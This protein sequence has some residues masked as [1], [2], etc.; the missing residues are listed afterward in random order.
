M[1][2]QNTIKEENVV[3]SLTSY[4]IRLKNLPN[5]L[6]T[7]YAQTMLPDVVVLNLAYDEII[8]DV[9]DVYLKNHRVIIN[10][11]HDTKVYKKIIP[12]FKLFPN[13]CVIC[14]DDDW[15]YPDGMIADFMHIHSMYPNNPISGNKYIYRGMQCHCGC[16]SLV[17]SSFFGDYLDSVDEEVMRL[18]HSS[19]ILYSYFA[20]KAGHPYIRTNGLYFLNMTPFNESVSYTKSVNNGALKTY[21]FLTERFG[22]LCGNINEYHKIKN[23][24]YIGNIIN[25]IENGLIHDVNFYYEKYTNVLNC[26]SYR[27]GHFILFPFILLKRLIKK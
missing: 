18:C 21:E 16:A 4:G 7:I 20:A 19:D 12:T 10:R 27:L 3:V 8:P 1:E 15:L 26:N 23:D 14:I 6:D 11:V 5:V 2:M 9:V 22:P 25:E 13:D 17:K 24:E